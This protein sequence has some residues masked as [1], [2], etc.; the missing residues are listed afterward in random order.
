MFCLEVCFLCQ[1]FQICYTISLLSGSVYPVLFWGPKVS[2]YTIN[3]K[4]SG[5]LI[6]SKGKQDD[7]EI[8]EITPFTIVTEDIK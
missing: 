4:K 1:D 2:V 8:R 5:A 6:Y 3:S 7:K